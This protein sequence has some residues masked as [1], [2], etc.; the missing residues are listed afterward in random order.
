VVIASGDAVRSVP[1]ATDVAVG[2]S[3][4]IITILFCHMIEY[5]DRLKRKEEWQSVYIER[6]VGEDLLKPDNST[7]DL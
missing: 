1:A 2:R 5:K 7:S 3:E 4:I 6:I